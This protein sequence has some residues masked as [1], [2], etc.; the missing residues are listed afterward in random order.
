MVAVNFNKYSV[1]SLVLGL[2]LFFGT[3][4]LKFTHGAPAIASGGWFAVL[5][6]LLYGGLLWLGIFFFLVGMLMILL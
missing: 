6:V 4:F 2:V 5:A 3:Y 1:L